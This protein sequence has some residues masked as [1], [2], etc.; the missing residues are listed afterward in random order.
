M[1]R[2]ASRNIE[3]YPPYEGRNLRKDLL[4]GS[5]VKALAKVL[6]GMGVLAISALIVV[7]D[8]ITKL[9][10]KGRFF[11]GE[12]LEVLGDF[13]RFTYIENPG[14]AFGIRIGG[15]Y[16]FTVFAT[17]AT[18]V[19]LFYLYRIRHERFLSRFSLALIFGGAIGNLI[20]RYAYGQVIDFIDVGIGNTRWPVFNI[21]D[22]AVTVGMLM[23]V[24][25][26][27][28]ER[29]PKSAEAGAETTAFPQKK[30]APSDESDNWREV[31]DRSPLA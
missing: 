18:A 20:D 13:F 6:Q 16:F 31:R 26:V 4:K 11:L 25:F 28:F 1:K 10:V 23:L 14:M 27:L 8:Q 29:D 24:F 22:S 3:R 5:A 21:A 19:I 17:L 30:S 9:S 15:K 2:T 12:S 7:L